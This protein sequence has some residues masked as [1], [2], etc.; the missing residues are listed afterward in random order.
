MSYYTPSTPYR[1]NLNGTLTSKTPTLRKIDALAIIT[2]LLLL[3]LAFTPSNLSAI[4]G[5]GLSNFADSEIGASIELAFYSPFRSRPKSDELAEVNRVARPVPIDIDGDG[6]VDALALPAFLTKEQ[7]L[8]EKKA[9]TKPDSTIKEWGNG[10]WGIR[11]LNL[12]PL[13]LQKDEKRE[14]YGP[15]SPRSMFLSPLLAESTKIMHENV[16]S[17]SA[18]GGEVYPL[19]MMAVHIPVARTKLGEEERSRQRHKKDTSSHGYGTNSAIPPKD[20]LNKD[21]DRTRHY[22]CGRDWHHASQSCH[23]HCASGVSSDCGEGEQCFADTPVSL[24]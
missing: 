10:S 21:Y 1:G 9:E 7:V 16:P 5:G 8:A 15:F 23:R 18:D 13:H 4:A 24:F 12:K 17:I 2:C 19:K 14:E 6:I 22:F 20:E 3:R 11:I